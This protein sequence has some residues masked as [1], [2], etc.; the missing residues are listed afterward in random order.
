MK[1]TNIKTYQQLCYI[2]LFRSLNAPAFG[3]PSTFAFGI[4]ALIVNPKVSIFQ[5]DLPI[6]SKIKLF[7]ALPSATIN[8]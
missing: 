4:C 3:G 8:K 5:L 1:K 7:V 2:P 6:S